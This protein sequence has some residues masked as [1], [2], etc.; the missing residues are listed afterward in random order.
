MDILVDLLEFL[1]GLAAIVKGADWLTD[2]AASIARHYGI[3]SIVV[4]LTIVAMGS[5]APEFVVSVV[6]ALQ[7]NTD[8]ALGNVVGSNIFN[9]LAIMGI[10]ALVRPIKVEHGNVRNDVPFVVL[11]SIAIALSALDSYFN[12]GSENSISR[13]DGLLLLCMF[14]IFM[15]YTFSM[16]KPSARK[17]EG[18]ADAEGA[19]IGAVS[20][21]ISAV[22]E[23]ISVQNKADESS[24]DGSISVWKSIGM[25]IVG[26]AGLIL[27][28][29]WLV[30]GASG[31]AI[32]IGIPE[33]VVALTIVSAGTS[34]PELAAS[35]MAARKGD[36]AMALGNVVGSCV[37]N[38]FFVLG[39]AA[40][41]QQLGIGGITAIDILVL[42]AAS[43]VLWLVCKCG[44]THYTI[45]R[46]EGTVLTAMMIAYYV[47]LV[48][49]PLTP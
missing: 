43:I 8:M 16:A 17:E 11:S 1:V 29:N 21:D 14:A 37:F 26:L 48:M 25:V 39:S 22:S 38:V 3:P 5:S 13:T 12:N 49:S 7:G 32:G 31:L 35:I 6:S 20:A 23:N 42:L 2:G 41:V 27:G 45:T 34:A 33:S 4:G 40:T 46:F 10:T 15:S 36:T 44:K 18:E 19:D 24:S 47:Y 9:I 28:G 30:E